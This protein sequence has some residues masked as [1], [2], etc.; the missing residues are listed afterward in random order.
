MSDFEYIDNGKSVLLNNYMTPG[1][2]INAVQTVNPSDIPSLTSIRRALK[3]MDFKLD[4]DY[5]PIYDNINGMTLEG[6]TSEPASVY[7]PTTFTQEFATLK[8]DAVTQF[9]IGSLSVVG[10]YILFRFIR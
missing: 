4:S 9:Y 10:L 1:F 3:G 5:S 8:K 2:E 7:E 6:F